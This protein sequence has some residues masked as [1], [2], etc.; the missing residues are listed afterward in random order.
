MIERFL[1]KK[2]IETNYETTLDA[3]YNLKQLKKLLRNYIEK[4]R[5]VQRFLSKKIQ[6]Q[7]SYK[8]VSKLSDDMTKRIVRSIIAQKESNAYDFEAIV[9]LVKN[10]AK[11]Q[12][13]KNS[14]AKQQREMNSRDRMFAS[15][16]DQNN[17][18]IFALTRQF[19]E[20]NVSAST[21][22][23]Q[24]ENQRN[25]DNVSIFYRNDSFN[26]EKQRYNQEN[27]NNQN[28]EYQNQ[29][30]QNQ[31]FQNQEYQRQ[32][33]RNFRENSQHSLFYA[34]SS[35]TASFDNISFSTCYN[36][37]KERHFFR[38]C[39]QSQAFKKTRDRLF[40]KEEAKKR[41]TT[42]SAQFFERA[43]TTEIFMMKHDR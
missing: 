27:Q 36:C 26:Q 23:R 8:L 20:F 2:K 33:N 31:R 29:E 25:A 22:E 18:T 42:Q 34:F 3:L 6:S 38:Q 43:R 21:R 4:A 15:I 16:L 30:Y 32:Q 39:S 14:I 12:D 24:F 37:E 10:I 17:K 40:R 19:A 35:S 5:K 1:K 7:I 41:A 11:N 13:K 28:Q 9:R